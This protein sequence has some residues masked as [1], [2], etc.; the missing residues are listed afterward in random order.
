MDIYEKMQWCAANNKRDDISEFISY[1]WYEHF[2][3]AQQ[4]V[5]NASGKPL[6]WDI[7]KFFSKD[8]IE[9]F[10]ATYVLEE[11]NFERTTWRQR[12]KP[13]VDAHRES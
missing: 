12:R 13:H 5:A 7:L 4:E 8:E 1:V 9:T 3:E 11:P 2:T 6:A 10:W